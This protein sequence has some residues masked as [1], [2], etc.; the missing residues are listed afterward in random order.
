M[1]LVLNTV[2]GLGYFKFFFRFLSCYLLSRARIGSVACIA[3]R[4]SSDSLRVPFLKQAR[5]GG[6]AQRLK[7]LLQ[8]RRQCWTCQ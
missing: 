2:I 7:L 5:R 4:D 6:E 1:F 3:V 8:N